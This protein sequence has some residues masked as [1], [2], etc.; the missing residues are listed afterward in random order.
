MCFASSTLTPGESGGAGLRTCCSRCQ[1]QTRNNGTRAHTR[2]S[3]SSPAGVRCAVSICMLSAACY[4]HRQ[5]NSLRSTHTRKRVWRRGAKLS[6]T[7]T[8]LV[9]L[10]GTHRGTGRR[11][12]P[13]V[14]GPATT[15][16]HANVT[17]DHTL[18]NGRGGQHCASMQGATRL[19]PNAAGAW[20]AEWTSLSEDCGRV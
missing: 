1:S 16:P 11:N 5:P 6:L 15:R 17:A 13:R 7:G 20:A 4:S 14:F 18:C 12:R 3:L 2:T 10:A 19:L 8:R 9:V